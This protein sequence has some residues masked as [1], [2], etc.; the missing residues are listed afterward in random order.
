MTE[1]I[2]MVVGYVGENYQPIHTDKIE[3][4]WARF[5]QRLKEMFE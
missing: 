4:M 1:E 2:E 3:K 5:A